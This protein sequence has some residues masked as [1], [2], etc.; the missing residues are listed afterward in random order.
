M[1][2]RME[3]GGLPY[4]CESELEKRL[5]DVFQL[6]DEE[7]SPVVV[8][9]NNGKDF[10]IFSWEDFFERFGC[11]YTEA[12]IEAINAACRTYREDI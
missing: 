5:E 8:H 12:E 7:Q 9:M 2:G 11:L 6:I 3:L 1:G 4:F 10:L